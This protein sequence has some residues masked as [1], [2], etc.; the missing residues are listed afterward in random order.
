MRPLE[1]LAVLAV[2]AGLLRPGWLAALAVLAAAAQLV[3][4]G[5]R[6]QM[7]PVYL[8]A[9]LA[10]L[11]GVA[12][13]SDRKGLRLAALCGAMVLAVAG[14]GAAIAF[15]IFRL[16]PPTGSA[17]VGTRLLQVPAGP[18][19]RVLSLQIW[20]PARPDAALATARYRDTAP[21]LLLS[22]LPLVPTH[23][24]LEAPITPG[25]HP[26]VLYAHGWGGFPQDNTALVEDLASHGFV[27]VAVGTPG[28]LGTGH[29]ADGRPVDLDGPLDLSS[30]AAT[31]TTQLIGALNTAARARDLVRVLD[32]LAA[33]NAGDPAGPFTGALQAARAGVLGFSFGGSVAAETARIDRRVVAVMNMDGWLFGPVQRTGVAVPYL[34]MSD[35]APL[36]A[37]GDETAADAGRRNWA[38]L[39]N[40]DWTCMRAG[41]ARHGGELMFL[42][43]SLHTNFSDRPYYSPIRRWSG[44]GRIDPARATAIQRRIAVTFF[45]RWLRGDPAPPPDQD[46]SPF[47]EI[48]R[49]TWPL[50][51]PAEAAAG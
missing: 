18:D 15:P 5:A 51:A 49:Q 43:G 7:V 19:G 45:G 9:S 50:P 42:T 1:I 41:F 10:V 8:A 35:D 46:G 4:E 22:H 17:P 21:G 47:P 36:P 24:R 33:L 14:V 48:R 38:I 2:L 20:Y 37:P 25:P 23:A 11:A 26:V 44:A 32:T 34:V 31:A 13:L 16:P 27:V 29:A 28:G 40:R 6:W 39:M 3:V 30:D 12:E